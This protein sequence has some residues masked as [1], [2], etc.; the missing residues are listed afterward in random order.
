MIKKIIIEPDPILRKKCES[1]EIVDAETKKL[2]KTLLKYIKRL[3]KIE[4]IF[5]QLKI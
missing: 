3:K 5:F 4:N 1:L 2:K